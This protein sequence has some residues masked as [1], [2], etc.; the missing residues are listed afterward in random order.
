MKPYVGQMVQYRYKPESSAAPLA[1]I[2]TVVHTPSDGKD[3]VALH[4]FS[5]VPRTI[6]HVEYAIHCR[7]AKEPEPDVYVSGW[8]GS[9]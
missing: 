9:P 4:I 6:P 5:E 2:V 7:T 3:W 1:A 8:A